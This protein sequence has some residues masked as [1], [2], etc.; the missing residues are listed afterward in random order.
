MNFPYRCQLGKVMIYNTD[1]HPKGK[2][3]APGV[4]I[5]ML[6]GPFSPLDTITPKLETYENDQDLKSIYPYIYI[7][8]HI[9]GLQNSLREQQN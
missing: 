5:H 6:M 7:Y 4:F 8:R 9:D 1:R 3:Y 2:V